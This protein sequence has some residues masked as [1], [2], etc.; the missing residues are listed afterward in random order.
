MKA[1]S[2]RWG[3]CSPFAKLFE[4]VTK[5]RRRGAGFELELSNEPGEAKS[6][7]LIPET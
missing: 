1:A 7:A 5:L 4:R 2:G 6:E 3:H